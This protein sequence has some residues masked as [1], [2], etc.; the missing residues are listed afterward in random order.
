M[1]KAAPN[2]KQQRAQRLW[3]AAAVIIIDND[4]QPTIAVSGETSDMQELK[5]L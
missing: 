2:W 3:S 5:R 1:L 4:D